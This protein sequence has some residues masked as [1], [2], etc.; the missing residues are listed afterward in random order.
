MQFKK[1]RNVH[2]QY[3]TKEMCHK[4]VNNYAHALESDPDCYK[5]HTMCN[6]SVNTYPCPMSFFPEYYRTRESCDK[7][8]NT[9]FVFNSVP[10]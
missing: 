10:N 1:I 4:V 8:V 9:F 7:A 6:K 2:D 5:T 3:K